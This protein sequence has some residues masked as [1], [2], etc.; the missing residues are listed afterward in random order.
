MT[1]SVPVTP[2]PERARYLDA[3]HALKAEVT[4]EMNRAQVDEPSASSL[5]SA[6][7]TVAPLYAARCAPTSFGLFE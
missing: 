3:L 6:W 1:P 7:A 5:L 2:W 4:R